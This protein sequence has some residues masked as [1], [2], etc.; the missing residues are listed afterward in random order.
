MINTQSRAMKAGEGRGTGFKKIR[1]NKGKKGEEKKRKWITKTARMMQR[2]RQ[3][4]EIKIRQPGCPQENGKFPST[5]PCTLSKNHS[6]RKE[7]KSPHQLVF[8]LSFCH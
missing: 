1:I 4:P 7:R 5:F 2:L 3:S 8:S 6:G